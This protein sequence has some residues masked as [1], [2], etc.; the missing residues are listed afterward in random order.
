MKIIRIPLLDDK[1][2]IDC[3]QIS[4]DDLFFA[5]EGPE[6]SIWIFKYEDIKKLIQY[7]SSEKKEIIYK[8]DENKEE[9]GDNK[10]DKINR[11][12]WLNEPLN[13]QNKITIQE[14]TNT[15]SSLRF[16]HKDSHI[17]FSSGFDKYII[18]WKI[19]EN[20]LSSERMRKIPTRHEIT[21][22]K[23]FPNDKYLFV[24]FINGE[25]N[26]YLCDYLHNSFNVMGTF[27]EHDDYI[28]SIVLSPNIMEDNLFI[29]MSDKGKLIL[30]EIGINN[31]KV[32]FKI[33]KNFPFENQNFFSKGDIKKIDWSS[34][35]NMII[36]VAHKFIQNKKIVH[37]RVIFLDD[38]DN[39]QPLIGHVSIPLI[40]KFSKHNYTYDN[41]IF[42]L[43]V[44]CDKASNIILWKVSNN[45]KKY[46]ILFSNYDFSDGIIKDIIFSND[47]KYLFFVSSFGSI[48]IIVFDELKI[49]NQ[50][51]DINT[52]INNINTNNANTSINNNK[53]KKKIIPQLISGFKP[54][55]LQNNIEN[56]ENKENKDYYNNK[57]DNSKNV[58]GIFIDNDINSNNLNINHKSKNNNYNFINDSNNQINHQLYKNIN[59]NQIEYYKSINQ[60]I[61]NLPSI[62]KKVYT[63]ENI[64]TKEGYY[65]LL[66]YEN[67]ITNNISNISL[68]LSNN[69]IL[70]IK[71]INSFIKVF[72]Y[73]NTYFAFYDFRSTINIYSL[74]GT[75]IYL[76]HYIAEVTKMELFENYILII[77]NDNQIIISD[78]INK[79]NIYNNKLLCLSSINNYIMQKINNIYFLGL[80]NIIIEIIESSIYSNITKK[81]IIYYNCENNDYILSDNDNLNLRDKLEVELKENKESFYVNLMKKLK[82][83]FNKKYSENDYLNIDKKINDIYEDFN[84]KINLN[85]EKMNISKN[86]KNISK[87]FI[88]FE[89]ISKDF[90]LINN[91]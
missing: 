8:E 56:K 14:H 55:L 80:N 26:I 62:H 83:D 87:S 60:Q 1:Y 73:N 44:T 37:A 43:L 21:D 20:N 23:L 7:E 89:F 53:P 49:V 39:S 46:R 71:Q 32:N 45:L 57:N 61:N 38:L 64:K 10:I 70:Y 17:L 12:Y 5:F 30:T 67:I 15:I 54:I 33:K 48:T 86:L 76:N 77:T 34:D 78:F 88:N 66:S 19:N 72:A 40:A 16:L 3:I 42:Q 65:L 31:D 47:G 9:K 90:D 28:N 41:E 6:N 63:F 25:I 2:S 22:M 79:K 36:S 59:Q 84:N 50:K 52:N 74:L 51:G 29:S 27:Y 82:F 35:G 18:I 81:I 13:L 85:N 58:E 24:G 68:K 91:I 4:Y 75:P 11:K 69:Y